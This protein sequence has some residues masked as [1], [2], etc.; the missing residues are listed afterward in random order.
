LPIAASVVPGLLVHGTGHFVGGDPRTGRRLL[1]MEGVGLGLMGGGLALTAGT[2]ASRRFV[3]PLIGV[4]VLGAGLFFVSALAD[5]YGVST[6][7]EGTGTPLTTT[8]IVQSELGA[9]YVY[10]PTFRYRAFLVEGLDARIGRVRISPSAWFALDDRNT[11]LRL[12]GA[13][14]VAGPR[15][16]RASVDGSFVDLEGAA[17]SHSYTSDGFTM[18]SGEASLVGRL[19]LLNVAP[20]LRGSFA[21]AGVGKAVVAYSYGGGIRDGNELLLARFACGAYLGRRGGEGGEVALTYDH[22]HDGFAAGL[23]LRGLASGVAGH[24]G[25]RG[26]WFFDSSWGVLGEVAVGSAWIT[27]VSLLHRIGGS[28]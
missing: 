26:F 7:G 6:G 21:E 13:L 22:R 1:A 12:E 5:I 3:G 24:F 27:G 20:S 18:S 14:R 17:M 25:A 11:R 10:D 19:D 23:K 2:G 15:P 16:D 4:T 28:R 9:R 8:P